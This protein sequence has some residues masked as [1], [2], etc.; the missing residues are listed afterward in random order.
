MSTITKTNMV[1]FTM[2]VPYCEY[3]QGEAEEAEERAGLTEQ[4][5]AKVKSAARGAM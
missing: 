3:I 1:L 5:V 4:A 2:I